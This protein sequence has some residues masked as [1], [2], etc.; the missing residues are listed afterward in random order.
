MPFD[1]LAK[2]EAL[3]PANLTLRERA[4]LAENPNDLRWRAIFPRVEVPSVKL[5]EISD[6]D[7]RPVGGRREW[8][9]DGREIP[10][11]VGPTRTIEM[12]P[13]NPTKHLDEERLQQLR[14]RAANPAGGIIQQLFDGGVI[15]TVDGWATT[16]A[17][18]ADRQIERDAFRAWFFNE[19][20]VKDTKSKASVTVSAGI[21]A[22]RY[23]AASA[24]LAASADAYLAFMGYL[25]DAQATLGS[26]GAVRLRRARL[27]EIL[28][29]APAL[30]GDRMSLAGLSE[31]IEREGFGTV[32]LVV[33]ERTYHEF[34]DGGSAYTTENYV[35]LTRMAFQPAN[36]VVGQTAFAPVTRAYDYMAPDQVSNVNDFTIFYSEENRGKTLVE[37]AQANAMS[38][39]LEQNV[40]VVTGIA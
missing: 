1:F 33:D 8:N 6:V 13:V 38:M 27:N 12:I 2:I 29:D 17:D 4:R 22:A 35:P 7:F 9:A 20:V 26:V 19:I 23:V 11:V 37:E 40:Y 32:A 28:A 15:K 14:E 3:T 39:P 21:N 25:S 10:D 36:G 24:T 18:A 5:S 16:L 30:S 31:R 34:T